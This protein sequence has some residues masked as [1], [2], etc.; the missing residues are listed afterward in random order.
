MKNEIKVSK[1]EVNIATVLKGEPIPFIGG[2][3]SFLSN[4]LKPMTAMEKTEL[5]EKDN[6]Q[7]MTVLNGGV[8]IGTNVSGCA[9][10]LMVKK[11]GT[12]AN[13]KIGFM[14]ELVVEEGG[15]AA[16]IE[17][18]AGGKLTIREGAIV[19]NIKAGNNTSISFPVAPETYIQGVVGGTA[20]EVK[21]GKLSGFIIGIGFDL[22]I[23]D[24]AIATGIIING[25]KLTV[26]K[27]GIAL[28][29]V[30]NGGEITVEDDAIVTYA[31]IPAKVS[32]KKN[33]KPVSPEKKKSKKVDG[34]KTTSKK[35][36]K[37]NVKIVAKSNTKDQS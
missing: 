37:D 5:T 6:L 1:G 8:A 4:M 27:G 11:G 13:A 30:N 36:K 12:V 17:L 26:R 28:D 34:N 9:T 21:E 35:T 2:F 18:D 29:V 33:E 16:G 25:G 15:I 19:T 3:F 24:G 32:A 22:C 20:F 10:K 23:S 31:P 14:G 7:T